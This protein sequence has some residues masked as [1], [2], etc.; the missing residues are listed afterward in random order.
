[1][2]FNPIIK[3]HNDLLIICLTYCMVVNWI[4]KEIHAL[5]KYVPGKCCLPGPAL[6]TGNLHAVPGVRLRH[7]ARHKYVS[8]GG[9]PG[10]NI[11]HL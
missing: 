5:Q 9:R 7:Y 8:D 4:L 6:V 3:V 10:N 2:N 11:H 1:M